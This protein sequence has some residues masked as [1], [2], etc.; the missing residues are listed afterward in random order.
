MQFTIAFI[1]IYAAFQFVAINRYIL[2]TKNTDESKA[3]RA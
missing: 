1:T 3:A 2:I